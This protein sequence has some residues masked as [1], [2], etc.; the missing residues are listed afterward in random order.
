MLLKY[1]L[2][3]SWPRCVHFQSDS[4]LGKCFLPFHCL[5]SSLLY[6]W[7]LVA[8]NYYIPFISSS[9][10]PS[11]SLSLS[12]FFGLFPLTS[13]PCFHLSSPASWTKLLCCVLGRDVFLSTQLPLHWAPLLLSSQDK[14][15]QWSG[16]K[17]HGEP[18]SADGG[19]CHWG[20]LR[21]LHLRGRQQAGSHKCQ[22]IPLQ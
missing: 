3:F 19:Q 12:S 17:E 20:A 9:C 14:Q 22:P 15:R 8:L 18:V 16:D 2:A 6:Q 10:F 13:P 7:H 11:W 4:V 5:G 21:E 1:R